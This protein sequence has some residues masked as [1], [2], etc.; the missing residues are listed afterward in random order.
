[1]ASGSL[2]SDLVWVGGRP[3]FRVAWAGFRVAWAEVLSRP[4]GHGP[5]PYLAFRGR[6]GAQE[7]P[8]VWHRRSQRVPGRKRRGGRLG[9]GWAATPTELGVRAERLCTKVDIQK[10]PPTAGSPVAP[11]RRPG[12][13]AATKGLGGPRAARAG[14]GGGRKRG[15][16]GPSYPRARRNRALRHGRTPGGDETSRVRL[17]KVRAFE[18]RYH[19][20]DRP[21]GWG[22]VRGG[23]RAAA[24]PPWPG[25]ATSVAGGWQRWQACS[26]ALGCPA[27]GR[28]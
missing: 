9:P 13:R 6:L 18:W 22:D 12:R 25:L 5:G 20:L 1:M 14:L 19:P 27:P 21:G 2:G 8:A 26:E 16:I 23:D 7:P 15:A 4:G 10:K 24:T 11:P 3:R 17:G 28:F